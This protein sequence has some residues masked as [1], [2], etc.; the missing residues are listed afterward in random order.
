V[1]AR[2]SSLEFGP[3]RAGLFTLPTLRQARLRDLDATLVDAAGRPTRVQAARARVDSYRRAWILEGNARVEGPDARA[4]C[5]KLRWDPI[6]GFLP[7]PRCPGAVSRPLEG[8][9]AR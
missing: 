5:A 7:S 2:A 8:S 6:A 4:T 1:D 9:A 3:A